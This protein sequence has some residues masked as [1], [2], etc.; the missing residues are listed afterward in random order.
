MKLLKTIGAIGILL[1]FSALQALGQTVAKGEYFFDT[2]PGLGKA[3]A[4]AVSPGGLVDVTAEVG[5]EG[6]TP[7]FH[8]LFMRFQ[9]QN[10]RWGLSEGRTFLVEQRLAAANSAIARAEYFFD[11]D[12]G[13]GKGKALPGGTGAMVDVSAEVGTEGLADGF[14]TLFVRFQD[15]KGHWGLSERRTFLVERRLDPANTAVAKGEFFFDS[16]PGLGKGKALPVGTGGLVD[17][18]AEVGTEG[19]A[20]GFHTLFVR[21]QDKQGRWG[22]S[23]GRAVLIRKGEDASATIVAAEY[24]FDNANPEPGKGTPLPIEPGIVLETEKQVNTTG[25]AL[26]KHRL[27]V[28]LRDS[29]GTWGPPEIKEF[30][31]AN[32]RLDAVTPASGGNVG[33]VTVNIVG[34]SFDKGTSVRLTGNGRPDI[35]VPDSMM[36]ILNGEQIRATLDLKS[37]TEGTYNVVITLSNGTVLTLPNGFRVEKGI[38]AAPWAEVLGF[39]R[40]RRGQWQTYTINYGNRGNVDAIGVPLNIIVGLDT[41]AEVKLDF[42]LDRPSSYGED[43]PYD[44]LP[45]FYNTD[46]LFN[47]QYLAKVFPLFI[48]NI[49]ANSMASLVIQV[50]TE[51]NIEL[52]AYTDAPYYNQQTLKVVY[53]DAPLYQEEARNWGVVAGRLGSSEFNTNVKECLVTV[54]GQIVDDAVEDLLPKLAPGVSCFISS[55]ELTNEIIDWKRGEGEATRTSVLWKTADAFQNCAL[56]IVP[57]GK[58]WTLGKVVLKGVLQAKQAEPCTNVAYSSFAPLRRLVKKITAVNSFDPNDKIG[59]EGAG[60]GNFVYGNTPFRYLIRFE[61]KASATAAAQTVKII[62]TLDTKTLDISTLQLG[63][64]NFHDKVVNIPPGR[65]NYTADVDLRPENDLIVRIEAKLDERKG[66]LTW[67]YTSLDPATLQPTKDPDAGFLPPNR[68]APQGEGGVFYTISPRADLGTNAVIKNKAYI[69]F[70]NNDVIPTPAWVNTIDKTPPSSQVNG[71]AAT[72]ASPKFTVEWAGKDEASGV[73][74]YSVFV[75]VNGG[76]YKLWLR[77]VP[78]T[79][80]QFTGKRDSTYQFYSIARDST[81]FVEEAPTVADATTKVSNVT[82]IEDEVSEQILVYPNPASHTLVVE[83]PEV[84]RRSRLSLVDMAGRTKMDI[85]AEGTGTSIPVSHLAKGIYL[86][87]I[88][89]GGS[90]VTRKVVLR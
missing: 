6:L 26:G 88:S 61:N 43:F 21:F 71:L 41:L 56:D 78:E 28:R 74:G 12:P 7:G 86:L 37:K 30:T 50:K 63:F 87:R 19:L 8:T 11:S 70:D 77:N 48:S 23:E 18:T 33:M 22:L 10:R 58:L 39:D 29:R 85:A 9:D 44:S 16:D 20:P 38:E 34:A 36:G 59:T 81:G 17:I 42:R 2:D 60:P 90:V 67:L 3:K 53:P 14:H 52:L 83:L 68:T 64:F 35:V 13:L 32:P 49:P 84:L 31:V 75:A 46:S 54:M 45:V 66:I 24:F 65:K 73:A 69:Y 40:I 72:Q 79:S 5:T 51:K 57:A 82:G 47:E 25:L 89:S 15:Q 62:D 1:L 4:L 80:A 55:Y 76:P 27:Q